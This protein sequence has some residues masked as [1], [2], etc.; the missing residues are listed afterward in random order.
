[1]TKSK[2]RTVTALLL[3][4]LIILAPAALISCGENKQKSDKLTVAVTIVPQAT[5]A[6][7]VC[8][9]RVEI[10]T[11]VP[12]GYS[13]ENYEPVARLMEKFEDADIYFSIG[14]PAEEARILPAAPKD[15]KIVA[16]DKAVASVYAPR[17]FEENEPDHHIWLS[18]KRAALMVRTMAE[19][20]AKLDPE[21]ADYYTERAEAYIKELEETDTRIIVILS[22]LQKRKF[23][24]YHPAFGYFADDYGLEMLALEE[25]G[26][27]ASLKHTQEMI[28]LAKAEG[29]KV[30]FYQE[31]IDVS[32][33]QAYAEE[34]GGRAVMLSPL[35]ADYIDNLIYMAEQIAASMG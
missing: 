9:D 20:M 12:P 22:G 28:D 32:R 33:S 1:M 15:L 35:A 11:L 29:L 27:E 14:V 26:K 30:I 6:E 2:H 24:A 5:F 10:I 18:P 4:A 3:C 34:I 7:A 16:L 23:V 21:Y 8:G 17:Y 25:E 13:P 19:E 31:E